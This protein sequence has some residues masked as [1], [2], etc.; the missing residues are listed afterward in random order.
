MLD[1]LNK[2]GMQ[3]IV[4]VVVRY[5]GGIKLGAGG[6][7]RAYGKSVSNALSFAKKTT[8]MT[9]HKYQ[10]TFSYDLIGK[11]DHYFRTHSIEVINKEYNEQVTYE[12]LCKT[13]IDMD[14]SE[15][16][17]GMY[18]PVFIEDVYVDVDI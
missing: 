16:S 9:M 3:D 2:A 12:Y 1:V 8:R 18:L 15:M 10:L 11:L 6:L 14:I 7:I 13:A 17:N 5:F 4:A